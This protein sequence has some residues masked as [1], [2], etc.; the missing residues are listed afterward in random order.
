MMDEPEKTKG[1]PLPWWVWLV[2]MLFPIPIG[3]FPCWVTVIFVGVFAVVVWAIT[4]DLKEKSS[5]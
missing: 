3:F 4:A 1:W 2:M 5:R